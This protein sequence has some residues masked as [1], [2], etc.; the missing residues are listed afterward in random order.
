MMVRPVSWR[1][2]TVKEGESI[3]HLAGLYG[4]TPEAILKMNG[5]I[6]IGL[7]IVGKRLLIPIPL[8]ASQK[9]TLRNQTG[10]KAGHDNG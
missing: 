1:F 3:S 4:V 8:A 5:L 7:L 10:M 2:H 6:P 9:V